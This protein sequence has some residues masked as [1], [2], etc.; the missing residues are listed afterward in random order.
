MA[1]SLGVALE[2]TSAVTIALTTSHKDWYQN[3]NGMPHRFG[4]TPLKNGTNKTPTNGASGRA[5]HHWFG[6]RSLGRF[7]ME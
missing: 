1:C 2:Y 5:S 4:S 7:N 3:K 6:L